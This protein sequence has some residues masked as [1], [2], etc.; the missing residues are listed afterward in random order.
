M[1][2]QKPRE[3]LFQPN[4]QRNLI[5]GLLAVIPLVVVWLVVRFVA[6]T[7]SDFGRPLANM[8][9]ASLSERFP[10]LTPFVASGA[11]KWTIALLVTLLVLYAIGAIT[12]RVIGQRL[13]ALIEAIITRIPLVQTVYSAARKLVD[14][15][16]TK[17][18]NAQRVVL[19]DFPREGAKTVGFVMRT[20]TDANT[21]ED[22]AAV[23]VPSAPNPTTGYLQLVAI[24]DVTPT[25]MTSEQ[26]M[27]MVMSAG[28]VTPDRFSLR[29]SGQTNPM[30]PST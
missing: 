13:W 18:E 29:D 2:D 26:A 20:F 30:P 11:A 3:R 6:E 23:F 15:L 17:P 9:A 21:G 12:N 5:A 22:V 28:A 10:A 7:L 16:R 25:D 19:I 1:S 24:K 27:A 14:V 4:F 8:F